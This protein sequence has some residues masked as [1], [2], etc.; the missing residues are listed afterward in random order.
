[1]HW[2]HSSAFWDDRSA[3]S[4]NSEN[5]GF[6]GDKHTL[7]TC[8]KNRAR[9]LLV[10]EEPN[11]HKQQRQHGSLKHIR[12]NP[13]V[14]VFVSQATSRANS[15]SSG[16][17]REIEFTRV[18]FGALAAE[19]LN[20][21]NY[22]AQQ[23]A[24][25]VVHHSPAKVVQQWLVHGVSSFGVQFPVV[26]MLTTD[27]RG[28]GCQCACNR[29]RLPVLTETCI[30]RTGV[31]V[32][33]LWRD[34]CRDSMKPNNCRESSD[35]ML[36]ISFP[37]ENV[38]AGSAFQFVWKQITVSWRVMIGNV[39]IEQWSAHLQ[40]RLSTKTEKLF[41]FTVCNLTCSCYFRRTFL[42]LQS[43]PHFGTM[44]LNQVPS[45]E[46]KCSTAGGGVLQRNARVSSLQVEV[47]FNS[48][49][50]ENRLSNYGRRPCLGNVRLRGMI[51][52]VTWRE[53]RAGSIKKPSKPNV[54]GIV[55][56][57]HA[58]SQVAIWIPLSGDSRDPDD[59]FAAVTLSTCESRV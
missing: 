15:S 21:P 5:K 10:N 47:T 59:E 14:A 39:V 34:L 17:T 11:L 35:C 55:E 37:F 31:K 36:C 26:A 6:L 46:F 9:F 50:V 43:S 51:N 4:E 22:P 45:P 29:R 20:I 44:R 7:K 32:W 23:H 19:Y 56:S 18:R 41:R 58:A 8:L 53:K 52:F 48:K 42:Q 1:M 40:G 38:I 3:V 33:V 27:L 12:R 24:G 25:C 13:R 54:S 28:G 49:V 57:A 16:H 30:F 2:W